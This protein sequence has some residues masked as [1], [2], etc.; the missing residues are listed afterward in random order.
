[1]SCR[2]ESY[3]NSQR[4]SQIKAGRSGVPSPEA[5]ALGTGHTQPSAQG[6][7]RGGSGWAA[8]RRRAHAQA[9]PS[10]EASAGARSWTQVTCHSPLLRSCRRPRLSGQV[11]ES[12]AL[13]S[14][15]HAGR[16]SGRRQHTCSWALAGTWG[17][18]EA[19]GG[20]SGKRRMR[21]QTGTSGFALTGKSP[22]RD[23]FQGQKPP[24]SQGC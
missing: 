17:F 20:K 12:Q 10:R 6:G 18:A 11:L 24:W 2:M 21:G 22:E 15:G 3:F 1:M 9:F 14:A 7:G 13:G 8:C 16:T 5:A 23:A 4:V 19:S